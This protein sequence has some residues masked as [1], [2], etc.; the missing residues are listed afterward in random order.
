MIVKFKKITTIKISLH[1]RI[2][3]PCTIR[4]LYAQNDQSI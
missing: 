1:H 3:V 2:Q 4:L